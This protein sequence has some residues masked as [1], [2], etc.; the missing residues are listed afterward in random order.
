MRVISGKFKGRKLSAGKDLSIRPTTDRVKEY[1]FSI[2]QDFVTS[3]TVADC[4]AGSG[5]LGIEALSRGASHVTF[6]EK[7]ETSIAVLKKNLQQL[8]ITPSLFSILSLTTESFAEKRERSFEIT[9]M[10]P[11]FHYPT[12]PTLVRKF[13][14][15]E[16][17][18]V[19]DLLVVEHEVINPLPQSDPAFNI[20]KQKKMGRSFVSFIE[21][22]MP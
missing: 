1:I 17:F 2:L 16:S 12:L 21:K 3:K 5:S 15:S 10:D 4:F 20:F 11:P 14:T 8:E 9:F 6:V 22:R 18:R 7:S 13:C 19:G